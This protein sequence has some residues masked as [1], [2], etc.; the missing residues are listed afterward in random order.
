MRHT[1]EEVITDLVL[2]SVACEGRDKEELRQVLKEIS[3]RLL[4]R[5]PELEIR[6]HTVKPDSSKMA[7]LSDHCFLT[8]TH[9]S[10]SFL[11]IPNF[12]QS[13]E[14]MRPTQE[15]ARYYASLQKH[16]RHFIGTPKSLKIKLDCIAKKVRDC[17]H[18]THLVVPPWRTAAPWQEVFCSKN[19]NNC[20]FIENLV[21]SPSPSEKE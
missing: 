1:T 4:V 17:M 6:L 10:V 5:F 13:W 15:F 14:L 20:L 18:C 9:H 16:Y 8:L 2:Q 21:A 19:T 12:A 11:F 3:G 7:C